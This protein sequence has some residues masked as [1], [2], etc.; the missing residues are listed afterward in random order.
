MRELLKLGHCQA[1]MA[2]AYRVA[3]YFDP[4]L[5]SEVHRVF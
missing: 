3:P 4:K 1:A 2:L 5:A